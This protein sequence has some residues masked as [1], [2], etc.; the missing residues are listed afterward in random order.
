MGYK[1][2]SADWKTTQPVSRVKGHAEEFALSYTNE[3]IDWLYG[4]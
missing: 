4:V 1:N 2:F 3:L